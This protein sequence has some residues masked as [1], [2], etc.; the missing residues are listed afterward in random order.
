[1]LI[2]V[3]SDGRKAVE[4]LCDVA[5]RVGGIRNLPIVNRTLAGMSDTPAQKPDG[6]DIKVD[7][8]VDR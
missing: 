1:M 3:D 5:L 7:D 2:E 4:A 8:S 6:P